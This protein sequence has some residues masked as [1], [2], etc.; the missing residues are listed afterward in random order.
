MVLKTS[1][2]V[3]RFGWSHLPQDWLQ[4]K[5]LRYKKSTEPH[6]YSSIPI[7]LVRIVHMFVTPQPDIN[8]ICMHTCAKYDKFVEIRPTDAAACLWGN[9]W[10]VW[11]RW[12]ETNKFVFIAINNKSISAFL[13]WLWIHTSKLMTHVLQPRCSPHCIQQ[14]INFCI[15]IHTC[16]LVKHVLQPHCSSSHCIQKAY[17]W[18]NNDPRP[19]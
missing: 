1:S 9:H 16:K 17:T 19:K 7:L 11:S 13:R 12:D 8:D 18:H 14:R 2:N 15:L 5:W 10:G 3:D 4:P 6:T